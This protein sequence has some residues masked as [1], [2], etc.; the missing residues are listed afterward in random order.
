[1]CSSLY[2]C[3][4]ATSQRTLTCRNNVFIKTYMH[5][6]C[7][8]TFLLGFYMFNESFNLKFSGYFNFTDTIS[9][10][11][12]NINQLEDHLQINGVHS[13]PLY[14]VLKTKGDQEFLQNVNIDLVNATIINTGMINSRKISGR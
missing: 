3:I 8:F 5:F 10:S 6:P 2:D 1:M 4:H 7:K 9:V 14:S 12:L 11:H 13:L